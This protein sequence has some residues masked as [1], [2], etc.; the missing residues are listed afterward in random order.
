MKIAA[1]VARILLG[2]LFTLMGAFGF[3]LV[4]GLVPVPPPPP[5]LATTFTEVFF[6]SR[7]VLFVDAIQ[8]ISGVLLLANRYVVLAIVMLGAVL[9]NIL[10]FHITMNPQGLPL[11]LVALALW[12][13][14]ALRYRSY[15]MPLFVAKAVP[16]EAA[17]AG[18]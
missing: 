7:W 5:G 14:L 2:L 13:V 8:L 12:I 6:Q 3:V 15:L 10:V 9:F 11:P 17:R 18:G 4:S 16:D 1:I